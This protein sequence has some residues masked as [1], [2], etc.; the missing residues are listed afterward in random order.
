MPKKKHQLSARDSSISRRQAR[1]VHQLSRTC[2]MLA[3]IAVVQPGA[4]REL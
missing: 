1:D 2:C 3:R 4:T